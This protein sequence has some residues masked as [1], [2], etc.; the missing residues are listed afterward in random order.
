[1]SDH[2][3]IKKSDWLLKED[4]WIQQYVDEDTVE[5][6]FET[7]QADE[8]YKYEN[9]SWWYTYRKK[10]LYM[11]CDKYFDNKKMIVD[12]GG[13]NGLVADYL[14]Q[15]GFN[16]GLIEPSYR[17]CKYALK[18][19]V[20][21]V[22]CGTVDAESILDNSL[23]QVML[24]DVLE[25]IEDDEKF[26]KLIFDKIVPGGLLLLTVPAFMSLWSSEDVGSGHYRRY[27]LPQIKMLVERWGGQI[28]FENYFFGFLYYPVLLGR[29]F[30][31][32][33]G[34]IKKLQDRNQVEYS[35]ERDRQ[36]VSQSKIVNIVLNCFESNEMKKIFNKKIRRGSSLV[37]VIKKV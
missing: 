13:G 29:V 26:Y 3:F 4:M 10:I 15:R 12:I 23:P 34:L 17:S 37:V 7:W 2:S 25:H 8:I 27:T 32:R 21:N 1:M 9:I 14:R 31:E 30:A 5:G 19:G 22:Y 16:T 20:K 33:V 28:A 11:V 35:K 24:L 18:R 36:Y 6:S